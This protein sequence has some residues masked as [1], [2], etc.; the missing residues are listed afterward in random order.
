MT[1]QVLALTYN[2]SRSVIVFSQEVVEEAHGAG[3]SQIL[4]G[5]GVS[6]KELQDWQTLLQLG[7]SDHLRH[8][9]TREGFTH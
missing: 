6:M 9:E 1:S 5:Q 7:D 3:H 2:N 8:R 4:K